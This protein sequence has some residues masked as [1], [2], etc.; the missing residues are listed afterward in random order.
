MTTTI[1]DHDQTRKA[2]AEK[3]LSDFNDQHGTVWT[4]YTLAALDVLVGHPEHDLL[5]VGPQAAKA[6][7]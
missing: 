1:H 7:G 4:D 5:F 6:G 3:A 2:N